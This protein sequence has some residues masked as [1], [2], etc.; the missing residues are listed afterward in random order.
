MSRFA[1][2]FLC[3]LACG[4]TV[5]C[6]RYSRSTGGT[7]AAEKRVLYDFRTYV[8]EHRRE[9]PLTREYLGIEHALACTGG[10]GSKV[11]SIRITPGA[12]GSF[13]RPGLDQAAVMVWFECGG[14]PQTRLVIGGQ[15]DGG[16][17]TSFEA[18]AGATILK[19][20]DLNRDGL[21]ELLIGQV[22]NRE[23]ESIENATLAMLEK[24]KLKTVEDFGQVYDDPCQRDSHGTMTALV[25]NYLPLDHEAM[26]KFSAE[27][28]RAHCGPPGRQPEWRRVGR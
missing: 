22:T 12:D 16:G 14:S 18:P 6:S 8:A 13:T 23:G 10:T 5:A 11:T 19:A 21:S 2:A 15:N 20:Y 24:G 9:L 4:V 26:P 3:L 17:M 7:S 1:R 27:L 25:I 28:Y